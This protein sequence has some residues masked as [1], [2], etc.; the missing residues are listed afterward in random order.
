MNANHHEDLRGFLG[1]DYI[2]TGRIVAL[3]AEQRN[4]SDHPNS[5]TEVFMLAIEDPT[6]DRNLK[7]HTCFDTNMFRLATMAMRLGEQVT[8]YCTIT[9]ADFANHVKALGIYYKTPKWWNEP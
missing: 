3:F 6:S 2:L 8:A 4:T 9:S 7:M 1:C 5:S